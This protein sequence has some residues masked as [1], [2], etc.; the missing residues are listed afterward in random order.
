[1]SDEKFADEP[2]QDS[3]RSSV[4]KR[5]AVGDRFLVVL[6]LSSLAAAIVFGIRLANPLGSLSVIYCGLTALLWLHVPVRLLFSLKSRRAGKMTML[7]WYVLPLL[8]VF[9]LAKFVTESFIAPPPP[10]EGP[11]AV[12]VDGTYS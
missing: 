8:V 12:C 2:T 9:F 7:L 3:A 6:L 1:M 4:R 11:T 5:G 10:S